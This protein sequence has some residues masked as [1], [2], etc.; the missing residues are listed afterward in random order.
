VAEPGTLG[1][2]LMGMAGTVMLARR[3]QGVVGAVA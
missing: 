1:L 3:R 2:V